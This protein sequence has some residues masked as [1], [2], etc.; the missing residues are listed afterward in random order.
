MAS[1]YALRL[2][3]RAMHNRVGPDVDS[4]EICAARR[5]SCWCRSSRV[6]V[7]ARALPAARALR[8][9]GLR[10]SA[11]ISAAAS[12]A[13]PARALADR[14]PRSARSAPTAHIVATL[15]ADR[16][17]LNGPHID[18]AALSPL[19][20]LLGGAVVVLLVGLLGSR[21]V[22]EQARA[23][24]DAWSRSARALGADDLAVERRQVDRLRSARGSTT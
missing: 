14:R 18:F 21:W 8:R 23:G 3:I 7:A 13:A 17:H 12:S 4:R 9:A 20:A 16:R 6:I 24:A 10:H 11:S 5:R 1:V 19:I 22:R 2:F 15:L